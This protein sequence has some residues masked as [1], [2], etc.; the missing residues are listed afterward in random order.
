MPFNVFKII[1]ALE[2]WANHGAWIEQPNLYFGRGIQ[3]RMDWASKVMSENVM[4]AR[5][6]HAEIRQRINGVLSG[7]D[8]LCLPTSSRIVPFKNSDIGK[9]EISYRYQAVGL[10]CISGLGGL[11]QISIPLTEL[12]GMPLGLSL[13]ARHG[14]NEVLLE[15]A[16]S[17]MEQRHRFRRR[18]TLML[19]PIGG[20]TT[21]GSVFGLN[22]KR[23]GRLLK[24][25]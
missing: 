11:P 22:L 25:A 4:A 18:A 2:V 16:E 24:K 7:N 1:Q 20:L 3:E 13:V 5:Q 19:D 14:N 23:Y 15:L 17:I 10:L 8:V 9:I 21:L 12:E 6:H